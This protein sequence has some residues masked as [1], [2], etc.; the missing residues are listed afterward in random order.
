VTPQR[1]VMVV[2][3]DGAIRSLLTLVLESHG[4]EVAAASD[5]QE[6]LDLIRE[7]LPDVVLTDLDMP[8]LDG[9]QLIS[10]LRLD[11]LV[12]EIPVIV[13][14]AAVDLLNQDDL[15]VR[16]VIRKP[17]RVDALIHLLESVLQ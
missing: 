5:G 1:C 10:N 17:F 9:W 2:D 14:S 13:V 12:S 4:Y 16:A 7:A 3:D 6:A 15:G 8:R 11:P